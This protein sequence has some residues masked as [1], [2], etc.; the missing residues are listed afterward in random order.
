VFGLSAGSRSAPHDRRCDGS[1][2]S[3]SE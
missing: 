2:P 3:T 1:L